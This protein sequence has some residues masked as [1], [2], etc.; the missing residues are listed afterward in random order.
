MDINQDLLNWMTSASDFAFALD[1]VD[2]SDLKLSE[3]DFH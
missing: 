1:V 3:E 2:T